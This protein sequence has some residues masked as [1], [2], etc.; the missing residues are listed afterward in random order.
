[1]NSFDTLFD[2]STLITVQV[3]DELGC[4][5][6]DSI[7]I[8]V[9]DSIWVNH[10][11]DTISYCQGDSIAFCINV[12]GGIDSLYTIAW[13]DTSI[14]DSIFCDTFQFN[15]IV[16]WNYTVSDGCSSPVN[17][18]IYFKTTPRQQNRK[19]YL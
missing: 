12:S 9:K 3:I 6:L 18:T 16:P 1:M 7:I 8:D 19:N 13:G 14:L 5:S 15:G 17:S 2:V 11:K 4:S 10:Y